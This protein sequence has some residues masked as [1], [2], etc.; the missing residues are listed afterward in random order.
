MSYIEMLDRKAIDA[1]EFREIVFPMGP[2]AKGRMKGDDYLAQY[3]LPSFY[4]H[5]TAAYAILRHNGVEIGKR[6]FLGAISMTPVS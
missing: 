5:L 2:S 4:F 3:V 6:D 1:S